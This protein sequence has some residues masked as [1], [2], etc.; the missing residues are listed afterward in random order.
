[1]STRN[2]VF[3]ALVFLMG[4]ALIAKGKP[5]T[6]Q[7]QFPVNSN[8]RAYAKKPSASRKSALSP[9][10][11]CLRAV[12]PKGLELERSGYKVPLASKNIGP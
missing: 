10:S 5:P 4:F 3:A 12:I 8:H 6:D 1:M 2:V 9:C 11:S 7:N